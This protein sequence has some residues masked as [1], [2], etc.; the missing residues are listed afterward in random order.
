M[1]PPLIALFSIPQGRA[2]VIA[3]ENNAGWF[4]VVHQQRTP[5]DAS[6]TPQLI[7][8]TRTEFGNSASEELAQQFARAVELRSEVS[9]NQD[10]I[11]R[12]RQ[13]IGG[14]APAAD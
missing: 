9:R 2:R 14:G 3:A 5:G 11:R 12:A 10:A 7:Q 1:P 4:I 13:Q 8:S 6:G